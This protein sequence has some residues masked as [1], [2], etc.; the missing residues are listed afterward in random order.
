MGRGEKEGGR[1]PRIDAAKFLFRSS[2]KYSHTAR[3][4]GR[5]EVRKRDRRSFRIKYCSHPPK[6]FSKKEKTCEGTMICFRDRKVIVF[7][8]PEKK[9]ICKFLRAQGGGGKEARRGEASCFSSLGKCSRRLRAANPSPSADD[10]FA[11][12]RRTRQVRPSLAAN[13]AN[14][15]D[16]VVWRL[17]EINSRISLLG[18]SLGGKPFLPNASNSA[19]ALQP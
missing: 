18:I 17:L 16:D 14:S 2:R 4:I 7:A 5:V 9:I 8:L 19:V 13:H 15:S 11:R 1:G 12:A 10:T 6:I 3:Y